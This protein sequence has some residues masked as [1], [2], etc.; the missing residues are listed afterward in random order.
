LSASSPRPP[1]QPPDHQ[2]PIQ[3]GFQL[4]RV[5]RVIAMNEMRVESRARPSE[6]QLKLSRAMRSVGQVQFALLLVIL[7]LMVVK[8]GGLIA[9]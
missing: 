3:G 7:F 9:G 6:E 5:K 8:P 1:S 4:P 2:A